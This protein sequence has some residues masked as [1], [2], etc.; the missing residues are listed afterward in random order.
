MKELSNCSQHFLFH[1]TLVK[2]ACIMFH[3]IRQNKMLSTEV[4]KVEIT[5]HAFWEDV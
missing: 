3:K 1:I 5:F 4:S 2:T